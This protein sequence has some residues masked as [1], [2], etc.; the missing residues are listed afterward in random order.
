[1]LPP[2]IANPMSMIIAFAGEE[3]P[4]EFYHIR[5]LHP[6]E[7]DDRAILERQKVYRRGPHGLKF[8]DHF[9]WHYCDFAYTLPKRVPVWTVIQLLA[10]CIGS[11]AKSGRLQGT[12]ISSVTP[13]AMT[14]VAA[15]TGARLSSAPMRA[16][17][18]YART[19]KRGMGELSGASVRHG[20]RPTTAAS[21]LE[22]GGPG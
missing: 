6:K 14:H 12:P 4:E 13:H 17:S 10:L 11:E 9:H 1:M 3:I 8:Q 2:F 18:I 22:G 20:C 15:P 5:L 21:I 19:Q 16:C 7:P